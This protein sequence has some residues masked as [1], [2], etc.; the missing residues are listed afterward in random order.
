MNFDDAYRD[1]ENDPDWHM[2]NDR[3]WDE[4]YPRGPLPFRARNP[5]ERPLT[6]SE[7]RQRMLIGDLYS[8]RV[9]EVLNKHAPYCCDQSDFND[10][11]EYVANVYRTTDELHIVTHF[12]FDILLESRW[13]KDPDFDLP[14]Y[15]RQM[16][17]HGYEHDHQH[18]FLSREGTRMGDAFAI[19]AARVLD[20]YLPWSAD[21][22][23]VVG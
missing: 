6:V 21:Y 8:D 5:Y 1:D 9:E 19:G 12:H 11:E 20:E 18:R 3:V 16:V 22:R 7:G 23:R 10:G 14:R 4:V 15:Y 13:L 17:V 2:G